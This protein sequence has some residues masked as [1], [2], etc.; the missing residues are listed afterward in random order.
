MP[1]R[2]VELKHMLVAAGDRERIRK[3]KLNEKEKNVAESL[4]M[5]ALIKTT[6]LPKRTK[7]ITSR[8]LLDEL[9]SSEVPYPRMEEIREILTRPPFPESYRSH[10]YEIKIPVI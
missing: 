3:L 6:S 2:L 5:L 8:K 9:L 10:L 7:I 1:L 4:I